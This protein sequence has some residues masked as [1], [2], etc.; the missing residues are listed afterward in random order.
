[1]MNNDLGKSMCVC[2]CIYIYIYIYI[3]SG[4]PA[5]VLVVGR[6]PRR[7]S[8]IG[9]DPRRKS[10][11]VCV[12]RKDIMRQLGGKVCSYIRSLIL[13]AL[14]RRT[15]H[16][17]ECFEY[18]RIKYQFAHWTSLVTWRM[19]CE[20]CGHA[21]ACRAVCLLS[22]LTMMYSLPAWQC[23]CLEVRRHCAQGHDWFMA[24]F[25]CCFC[26]MLIINCCLLLKEVKILFCELKSSDL[27]CIAAPHSCTELAVRGDLKF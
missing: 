8:G 27:G 11:N 17:G 16:N 19:W 3:Y 10:G 22:A 12:K 2:V 26:L 18:L 9:R 6:D 23:G 5:Y 7:K 15:H 13:L 4:F 14:K 24:V 25:L 21:G 20:G 1:M